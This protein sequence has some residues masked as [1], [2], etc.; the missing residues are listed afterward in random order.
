MALELL[1]NCEYCASTCRRRL[2]RSAHLH[3]QVHAIPAIAVTEPEQ[4]TCG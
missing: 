2:N 1:L 4:L 3:V